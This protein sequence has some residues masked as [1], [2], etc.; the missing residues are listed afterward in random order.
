[1]GSTLARTNY[2][3]TLLLVQTFIGL[4]ADSGALLKALA[5]EPVGAAT[6]S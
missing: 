2:E 5:K 4:V 6:V 1:V 3:A